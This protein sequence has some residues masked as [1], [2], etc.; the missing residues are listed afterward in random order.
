MHYHCAT[1]ESR[2]S[3]G[4]SGGGHIPYVMGVHW[5]FSLPPSLLI[6][7]PAARPPRFNP[8]ALPP[9][10]SRP[11]LAR[12]CHPCALLLWARR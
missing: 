5:P 7:R 6:R 4:S 2:E 1:V 8:A 9:P 3:H 12:P 10:C 11:P